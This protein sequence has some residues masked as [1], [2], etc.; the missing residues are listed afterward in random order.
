MNIQINDVSYN[1]H[2]ID[3]TNYTSYE[4]LLE[5]QYICDTVFI[6]NLYENLS[7]SSLN[8]DG[9]VG[10]FLTNTDN[11]L[12]YI[13]AIVDLNCSSIVDV[14]TSIDFSNA[15]DIILFC[16]NDK[17]RVMGLTKSFFKLLINDYIPN[18]KP[19]VNKIYLRVA[20]GMYNV[21]A[22][23]FYSKLGFNLIFN[24]LMEYKYYVGGKKKF[25]RKRNSKKQYKHK[26]KTRKYNKK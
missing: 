10:F 2:I 24:N 14:Y 3:K 5:T 22:V 6:S 9:F 1:L 13:S 16:A 25:K 12:L 23:D 18:Y 4:N 20:K 11:N 7:Y 19:G 17:R 21:S 15:V 8:T 26:R